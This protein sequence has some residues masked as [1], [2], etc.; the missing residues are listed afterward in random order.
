M[1]S[2][3]APDLILHDGP[4]LTIDGS[5][6]AFAPAKVRRNELAIALGG[7]RIFA[8]GR[9][10][11]V[12]AL[13][14]PDT[15]L[16]DLDGAA[17]LPGFQDQH[18]HPLM[19]GLQ[20]GWVDLTRA[21]DVTAA[22]RMLAGA[23]ADARSS[24]E[25]ERWVE[26]WYHPSTWRDARHPTRDELDRIVPD[27]PVLLHHGS[28][29]ATLGNSLALAYAGITAERSDPPGA[30]IER[31]ASGEPT[32]M[33]RGS[34]PVAPFAAALPPL[35]PEALRD[36]VRR[37]GAR[38]SA[39]GVT[40]VA[41]ANVGGLGDPVSEIAAY[42]GAVRD[43]DFPQRLTVMPG[44]AHLAVADEDPPT[45][46]DI[47][48][49]VPSDVR[50]RVRVGP[51]KFFADGALS[52]G[53]AWLRAPY[54]DAADRPAVLSVGQ[55]AYEPEALVERLRRAHLSGWQLA[56]HAIGDAGIELTLEAYR[57]ILAAH[58]RPG[59]RHR[60]EH[61]MVLS[62]DLLRVVI[63]LE[64]VA[65]LQPE[66]VTGT[67]DVYLA[68]LGDRTHNLYAYRAWIDAGLHVA[69]ASDRPFSPGAPLDGIR[70][71]FRLAGPS[72][73]RLHADPGPT[74]AEALRAWTSVAAWAARDEAHAGRL[75]AGLAADLVVL[76][77]D[78]TAV[79]PERWGTARDGVEVLA[80]LVDGRTVFGD[81]GRA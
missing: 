49:L 72:G 62:P 67:G 73:R 75:A 58:P 54:E 42:V 25:V 10:A 11:D 60:V 30:T 39:A 4:I 36:A 12:L 45:P 34:D 74:V 21:P 7:G 19:E 16:V 53:D 32:G 14:G 26:A 76:S 35:S 80:T 1:T 41:D 9:S 43:G 38:L 22:L 57:R 29:H 61:S 55:P 44:L 3:A 51:A 77:A 64:V 56:T 65:V 18:A 27:V 81:L 68:R 66:F 71:A 20:A 46:D 2:R 48:A 78:P 17:V 40:A 24:F 8:V 69:F 59:H 47:T 70:A 28:G 37:A 5:D 79:A 31:D 15:Q 13:A 33:V 6:D 23:A 52:T 63:E 50:D